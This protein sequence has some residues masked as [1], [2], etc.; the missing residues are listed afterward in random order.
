[1]SLEGYR[2]CLAVAYRSEWS[3]EALNGRSLAYWALNPQIRI[4]WYQTSVNIGSNTM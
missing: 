3:K 2:E 4:D 1:M